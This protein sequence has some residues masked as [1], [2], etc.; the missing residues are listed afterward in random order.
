MLL[1]IQVSSSRM[2]TDKF[3]AN[4]NAKLIVNDCNHF[5]LV[6]VKVILEFSKSATTASVVIHYSKNMKCLDSHT[7]CT[8]LFILHVCVN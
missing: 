6:S 1:Y 3:M 8:R 4:F 2:Q 7:V 5:V